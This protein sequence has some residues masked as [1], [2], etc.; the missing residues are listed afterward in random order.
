MIK[1]FSK[2]KSMARLGSIWFGLVVCSFAG[3]PD[4]RILS[5]SR[6]NA[7]EPPATEPA[8]KGPATGEA[9]FDDLLD[10]LMIDAE[11]EKRVKGK[12]EDPETSPIEGVTLGDGGP[13]LA[14][15]QSMV[16][17]QRQLQSTDE[18]SQAA[19]GGSVV[20][21]Q[22]SAID[23]LDQILQQ[24]QSPPEESQTEPQQSE[25]SMEETPAEEAVSQQQRESQEEGK[26]PESS[27]KSED[28]NGSPGDGDSMTP[29]QL[30]GDPASQQAV[31][32]RNLQESVWGHLPDQVRQQLQA[33][34]PEQFHPRYQQAIQA[35]YQALAEA[36]DQ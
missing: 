27:E 18:D 17:A 26:K 5:C 25:T 16:N 35:Y 15:Y 7:Q 6:L 13:L 9:A 30:Q 34:L 31:N 36:E 29:E 33:S 20:S 22:Q 12:T 24:L 23:A 14:A 1:L 19:T 32:Q 28:P 8:T 11:P 4:C 2:S 21:V 10:G 3:T